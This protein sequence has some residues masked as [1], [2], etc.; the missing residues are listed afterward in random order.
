MTEMTT[1]DNLRF[2]IQR[3]ML[4][5]IPNIKSSNVQM[6]SGEVGVAAKV[7]MGE[8][9]GW[10]VIRGLSRQQQGRYGFQAI[11]EE[12]RQK[13]MLS[14]PMPVEAHTCHGGECYCYTVTEDNIYFG[15]GRS[16]TQASGAQFVSRALEADLMHMCGSAGFDMF[17]V[18]PEGDQAV[19]V[20]FIECLRGPADGPQQLFQSNALGRML[21][22]RLGII[23]Q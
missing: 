7:F 18:L 23:P 17:A 6:P 5:D 19:E 16:K 9:R 22:I 20:G 21:D 11:I 2:S 12:H 3:I 8:D 4:D 15:W 14:D 1:Y 10:H 13:P